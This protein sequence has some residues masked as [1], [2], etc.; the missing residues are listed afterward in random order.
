VTFTEGGL[1]IDPGARVI[2]RSGAPIPGLYAAGGDGGGV[3]HERY[4]GGL[5]LALVFGRI[6]GASAARQI[7]EAPR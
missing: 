1:R 3:Y 6:A 4:A 7:A 5:S 2:G